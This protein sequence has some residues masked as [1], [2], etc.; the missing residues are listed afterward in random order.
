MVDALVKDTPTYVRVCVCVGWG[1][2]GGDGV[3]L[4]GCVV[5]KSSLHIL[6]I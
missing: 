5:D 6:L 4:C 1:L 3:C 2:D